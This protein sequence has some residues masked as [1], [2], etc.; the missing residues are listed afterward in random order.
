MAE[1]TIKIPDPVT[2]ETKVPA[3]LM[4]EI[5]SL[6][7]AGWYPDLDSVV[8]EALRRFA[9]TH[10]EELIEAFAREDLEWGLRGRD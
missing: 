6:V 5:E 3:R 8:L 10:R 7:K 2:I 4:Q 1:P 9:D